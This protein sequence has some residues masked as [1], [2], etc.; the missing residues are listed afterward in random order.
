MA[1]V[2]PSLSLTGGMMKIQMF[3]GKPH[4]ML[5][6]LEK[7]EQQNKIVDLQQEIKLLQLKNEELTE[8]CRVYA[9][10]QEGYKNQLQAVSKSSY[11]NYSG[12]KL[13]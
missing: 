12:D 10:L 8:Q 5:E 2:A 3:T 6:N 13:E 11:K 7:L 9:E 4:I 1:G